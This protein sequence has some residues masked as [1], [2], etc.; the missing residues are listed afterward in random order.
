MIC[1]NMPIRCA[2][3]KCPSSK[4]KNQIHFFKFPLLIEPV[5]RQWIQAT[6]RENWIPGES[7]RICELHFKPT[8]FHNKP[9]SKR[10]LLKTDVVPTVKVANHTPHIKE[11][12]KPSLEVIVLDQFIQN[13][14]AGCAQ[15]SETSRSFGTCKNKKQQSP[16][17]VTKLED[18]IKHLQ[19]VIESMRKKHEHDLEVQ[20]DMFKRLMF[21][22]EEELK[23]K[24][25]DV[26]TEFQLF[27]RQ[28]NR[29]N[30]KTAMKIRMLL[31]LIKKSN[32]MSSTS[33]DA[34]EQTFEDFLLEDKNHNQCHNY[35]K[36]DGQE[37]L[38]RKRHRLTKQ[39]FLSQ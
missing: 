9:M 17:R 23:K 33:Y 12:T 1:G 16:D 3:N 18:E 24:K 37:I 5:L 15:E 22:T 35:A 39:I 28:T 26:Q 19:G 38:P 21:E 10:K 29:R 20:A 36:V 6:G 7:S 30:V 31:D 34:L 32:I 14:T 4:G 25:T 2:V 11:N 8:D 13:K 27:K